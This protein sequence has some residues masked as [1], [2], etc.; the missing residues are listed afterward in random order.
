VHGGKETQKDFSYEILSFGE[1]MKFVDFLDDEIN[2]HKEHQNRWYW[3]VICKI[4]GMKE[5]QEVLVDELEF[6]QFYYGR[7]HE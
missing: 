6:I 3:K 7:F 4:F 1:I 5:C 2:F